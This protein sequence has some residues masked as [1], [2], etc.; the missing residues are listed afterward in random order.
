[1]CMEIGWR[2]RLTVVVCG[3]CIIKIHMQMFGG[4]DNTI[5][6]FSNFPPSFLPNFKPKFFES[7]NLDDAASAIND[8]TKEKK[9]LSLSFKGQC[10]FALLHHNSNNNK[11]ILS[12]ASSQPFLFLSSSG[13]IILYFSFMLLIQS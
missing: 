4:D 10:H 2:D 11:M 5:T 7:E 8:Y 6:P 13:G 1:M 3:C 12:F 9:T